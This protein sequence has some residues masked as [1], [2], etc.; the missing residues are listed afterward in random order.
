MFSKFLLLSIFSYSTISTTKATNVNKDC[1]L[2]VYLDPYIIN[3]YSL[4][5]NDLF[6]IVTATP[7][8]IIR[9]EGHDNN[10]TK[11]FIFRELET[12]NLNLYGKTNQY[13][14]LQQNNDSKIIVNGDVRL[15]PE[16]LNFGKTNVGDLVY[17]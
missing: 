17:P 2:L 14:S 7:I 6:L 12:L 4:L 10:K 5:K 11:Y 15:Y 3:N 16:L 13:D 9:L 8:E 1:E